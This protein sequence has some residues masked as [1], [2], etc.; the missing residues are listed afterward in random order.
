[1]DKHV[2]TFL[3]KI[4]FAFLSKEFAES[5]INMGAKGSINLHLL[6]LALL[7]EVSGVLSGSHFF[8]C[9]Y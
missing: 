3:R 9:V 7:F 1:M 5:H 4:R 8:N 6:L 2:S